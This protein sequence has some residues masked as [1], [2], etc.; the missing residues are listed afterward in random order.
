MTSNLYK[1]PT[2]PT[3]HGASL[4]RQFVTRRQIDSMPYVRH[5]W[6]GQGWHAA[7]LCRPEQQ[8]QQTNTNLHK[9]NPS[10]SPEARRRENKPQRH[11]AGTAKYLVFG[12]WTVSFLKRKPAET[13]GSLRAA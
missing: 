3:M 2:A 7:T 9:F 12:I 11:H 6:R 5:P 8:Q 13:R 4:R 10:S 1:V